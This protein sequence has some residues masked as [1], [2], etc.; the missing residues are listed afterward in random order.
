MPR[1]EWSTSSRR[2]GPRVGTYG[3]RTEL[4]LG[5]QPPLASSLDPDEALIQYGLVFD[6]N[7]D[8]VPDY[9]LGIDNSVGGG[10]FRTWL[11]DLG[12]DQTKEQMGPP[13]GVPFEFAHPDEGGTRTM[14]FEFLYG[15]RPFPVADGYRYYAWS[16]YAENGGVV[17]WDYAPDFGW[18]GLPECQPL[19]ANGWPTTTHNEPGLYSWTASGRRSE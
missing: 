15:R 10:S 3:L 1:K 9:E 17:A 7:A 11:T 16:S 18:L 13:Y 19:P 14:M 2:T 5:A 12:L 8:G 4:T 6:T